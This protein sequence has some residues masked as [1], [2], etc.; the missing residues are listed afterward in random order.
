MRTGFVVCMFVCYL[1]AMVGVVVGVLLLPVLSY[2]AESGLY[3]Q[4]TARR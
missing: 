1:F 2:C 3:S 4:A